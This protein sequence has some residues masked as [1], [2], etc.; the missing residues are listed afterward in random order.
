LIA[1]L[2]LSFGRDLIRG[3][4]DNNALPEFL[5]T[6]DCISSSWRVR[7][8]QWQMAVIARMCAAGMYLFYSRQART[9][10]IGLSR[11]WCASTADRRF[12]SKDQ[13]RSTA[14]TELRIRKASWQQ[15]AN[16]FAPDH[17]IRSFIVL[18]FSA[19]SDLYCVSIAVRNVDD[20]FDQGY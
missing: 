10:G 9:F 15:R 3:N 7:L 6:G 4:C 14:G 11:D 8:T 19:Q 17:A 5:E 12:C 13:K 16:L 18:L 2:W 1:I 20:A